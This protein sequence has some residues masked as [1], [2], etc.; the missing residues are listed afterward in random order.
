LLKLEDQQSPLDNNNPVKDLSLIGLIS[1]VSYFGRKYGLDKPMRNAIRFSKGTT[2]AQR[3][4]ALQV[5][6][7]IICQ[8]PDEFFQLLDDLRAQK[9]GTRHKYGL[10][11]DFGRNNIEGLKEQLFDG[12]FD[13]IRKAFEKYISSWDNGYITSRTI[14]YWIKHGKLKANVIK[15]G[16]RRMI[17]IDRHSIERLSEDRLAWRTIEETASI[18]NMTPD[19]VRDL[20]RAEIIKPASGPSID[21]LQTTRIR[22]EDIIKLYYDIFQVIFDHGFKPKSRQLVCFKKA[23]RLLKYKK[24]SWL[25]FVQLILSAEIIPYAIG[26]NAGL[27]CFLFDERQIRGI[28]DQKKND[29]APGEMSVDQVSNSLGLSCSAIYKLIKV[30]YLEAERLPGYKRLF[31]ISVCSVDTFE[32]TYTIAYKLASQFGMH[33]HRLNYLLKARGIHPAPRRCFDDR[34]ITLYR[35]KDIDRIDLSELKEK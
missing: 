4:R 8:W 26:G 22:Y 17:Q 27:N 34:S 25:K 6:S 21:G 12:E 10:S 33:I 24:Y 7:P 13:F 23:Y 35:K 5:I 14:D 15:S 2:C 28:R 20:I 29:L 1:M 32:T 16:Q 9:H 30:G 18:Y 3:H 19:F 11:H 31:T